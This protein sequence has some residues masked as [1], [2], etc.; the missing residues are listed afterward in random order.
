MK[1]YRI[2][3]CVC[4]SVMFSMVSLFPTNLTAQT[5]PFSFLILPNDCFD[6]SSASRTI[7]LK[8]NISDSLQVIQKTNGVYFQMEDCSYVLHPGKPILPIITRNIDIQNNEIPSYILTKHVKA[9]K[10]VLQQDT[11]ACAP[12]AKTFTDSFENSK[13]PFLKEENVQSKG[14]IGMSREEPVREWVSIH[15]YS[16]V[17]PT[18]NVKHAIT[19]DEQ[20]KQ[21]VLHIHPIYL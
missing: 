5:K 20:K 16:Q 10:I 19:M 14:V 8:F 4:L 2:I 12:E 1:F 13:L 17:F 9:K 15:E 21:L 3:L 7:P 18:V 6:Q 11:L